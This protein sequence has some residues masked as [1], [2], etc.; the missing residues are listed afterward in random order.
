VVS[1]TVTAV[2]MYPL[3]TPAPRARIAA[4]LPAARR[5]G[6]QMSFRATLTN[7]EYA[8]A[9]APARIA[10]KA[11]IAGRAGSRLRKA[12]HPAPDV[13]VIHRLATPTPIP[14]LDPPRA[15]DVYDFDDALHLGDLSGGG[16]RLAGVKRERQR[17]ARYVAGARLVVAGNSYLADAAMSMAR[18]VEIIPTCVDVT[19]QPL[20]EHHEGAPV[21]VGWMGSP[22][23]ATYLTPVLRAVEVL[24]SGGHDVVMHVVGAEIPGQPHWL[25]CRPWSLSRER[26]DL[27]SFD[28]GVMPL[29]DDPWTRG[30]CGYKLLQYHAAGVPSVCSPVGVNVDI[31]SGGGGL[32]A[33]NDQE[34]VCALASL[35]QS[36]QERRERGLLG[37]TDVEARFSVDM[38]GPRFAELIGELVG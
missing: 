9:S 22:S 19:A 25:T 3:V 31:S 6:L 8:I 28:I 21:V 34:W 18:R 12:L 30:K 7:Q 33:T 35:A 27:A 26:A 23:T 1:P 10:R 11:M 14:G 15:V 17:W 36:S 16:G 24:R 38:W 20:R 32:T 13:L 29:S 37:R 5:A 2:S 4:F